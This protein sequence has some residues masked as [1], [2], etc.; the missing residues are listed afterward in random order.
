MKVW[1]N[2]K[3]VFTCVICQQTCSAIMYFCVTGCGQ[4][5]GCFLCASK[6][7]DCPLCRVSLPDPE[8]RKP[9]KVSGLAGILTF[10]IHR[11]YGKQISMCRMRK[12][13][14][15]KFFNFHPSVTISLI[16]S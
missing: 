9:M 1:S 4:L 16:V 5:I 15:M 13:Q 8:L 11:L 10:P 7:E 2:L 3:Q 6:I 12:I 14:K